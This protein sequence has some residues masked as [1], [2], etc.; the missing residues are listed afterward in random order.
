MILLFINELTS[1]LKVKTTSN[2]IVDLNHGSKMSINIDIEL[3]GLPCSIISIDMQDQ[4][5][6]HSV[7]I[8]GNLTRYRIDKTG[9]IINSEPYI[10]QKGQ[11]HNDHHHYP[12]PNIDIVKTQLQNKEG[13]RFKGYFRVNKV[14]GNFHISS[15]V[16]GPTISKLAQQGLLDVDVNH[17][18]HHLSFGDLNEIQEIK[19]HFT[20]GVLTPMNGINRINRNHKFI[21]EY[22]IKIVPTTYK[23]LNGIISYVNQYNYNS[24]Q[25]YVGNK[26]PAVYFKYEFSPVTVQY[27][28]YKDS[29]LNFFIQL[30]AILGGVFTVTGII[31]A[32]IHKSVVSIIKKAERGKLG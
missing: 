24:N 29:F 19:K 31:D 2:M 18:I 6:A 10:I 20:E 11:Q 12:Q 15:H 3:T 7:N 13:C 30:C 1:Y 9:K 5:G 17:K 27:I 14:P 32:L 23:K 4:M 8:D 22:Y 28:Q 21:Y 26:Y 25:L 16:F